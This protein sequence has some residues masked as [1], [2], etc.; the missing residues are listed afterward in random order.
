[1][2]TRCIASKSAVIPPLV[3][4]PSIQ[5][6]YTHGR[7]EAGGWAKP[8][9]ILSAGLAA[10]ETAD[11]ITAETTLRAILFINLIIFPAVTDTSYPAAK[12]VT[13]Q[14]V[15]A[16]RNQQRLRRILFIGHFVL[17]PETGLPGQI[18]SDR[19]QEAV[20]RE[21]DAPRG[22]DGGGSRQKE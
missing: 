12:A 16:V 10:S 3:M 1:M 5:N 9:S 13:A 2:P 18:L 17:L 7:A 21:D 15:R 8:L 20:S 6:Q 4:L 11:A 22:G 19:V 14:T